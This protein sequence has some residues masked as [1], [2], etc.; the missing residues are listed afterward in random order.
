MLIFGRRCSTPLTLQNQPT[1][2]EKFSQEEFCLCDTV[3]AAII[4][5]WGVYSSAACGLRM[6]LNRKKLS[7]KQ[8]K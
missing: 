7:L 5:L 2:L 3:G 6:Y 8:K 1:L 4:A